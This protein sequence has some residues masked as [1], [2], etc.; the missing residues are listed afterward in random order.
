MR[1]R[2]RSALLAAFLPALVALPAC[3]PRSNRSD[4]P[5]VALVAFPQAD[6]PVERR[7]NMLWIPAGTLLSGTP[8]DALPRVSDVEPPG[9]PVSLHGFHIDQYPFPNEQGA[10]QTTGLTQ[11]E[12]AEHCREQSKRLCT[13]LE[14]E[15]ACKGPRNT[16]YEYGNAW[17]SD[18]C[19][20]GSNVKLPSGSRVGCRSG[21]DVHDL[22][23]GAAEWTASSWG[24]GDPRPLITLRGGSGNPGDVTGRCAHARFA[25][26]DARRPDIGFRCC[27]GEPNDAVVELEV[28]R[29][30]DPFVPVKFDRELATA[31]AAAIPQDRLRSASGELRIDRLWNWFPAGNEQLLVGAGCARAGRGSTCGIVVARPG[32][33]APRFVA[34]ASSSGWVPLVKVDDDRRVVWLFGVDDRGQFRRR[35]EY[36]WGRVGVGDEDRAGDPRKN[37][38]KEKD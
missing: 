21:F 8:A 2:A 1:D 18:E 7:K 38:D 4:P 20:T 26:A 28:L 22:H 30:A 32:S 35:I 25:R 5:D 29:A 24:R 33:P 27:A 23:G 9:L 31:L 10:I 19:G 14:W 3:P 34:F 12:A 15:R 11:Q 37:K 17:R 13:E 16:V 6:P 36:L